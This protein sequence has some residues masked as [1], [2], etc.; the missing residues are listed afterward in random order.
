MSRIWV[1][2]EIFTFKWKDTV[3]YEF[4][5]ITI[6]ESYWKFVNISNLNFYYDTNRSDKFLEFP[7]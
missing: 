6:I 7:V 5:S 3:H 2:K 4:V 1:H